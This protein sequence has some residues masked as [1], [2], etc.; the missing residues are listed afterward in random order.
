MQQ[1]GLYDW[2]TVEGA[3]SL[4]EDAAVG[5]H[6]R[7]LALLGIT[8]GD[9]VLLQVSCGVMLPRRLCLK[10]SRPNIGSWL[11]LARTACCWRHNCRLKSPAPPC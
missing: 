4:D 1:L 6:P 10:P 9:V 2:L 5:V 3:V 7:T 8:S 11:A